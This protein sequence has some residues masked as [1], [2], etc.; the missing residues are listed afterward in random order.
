MP[1]PYGL[2]GVAATD[3]SGS[4]NGLGGL[5]QGQV[6]DETEEERKKRLLGLSQQQMS[7]FASQARA[8]AFGSQQSMAAQ[9]LFGSS[10]GG[11][12]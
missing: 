11:R 1:S 12:R 4:G 5:L 2:T 3:L 8:P 10:S 7:P 6:R 9:S